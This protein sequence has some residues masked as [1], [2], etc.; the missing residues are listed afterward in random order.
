M[1][2]RQAELKRLF[3][4]AAGR[5]LVMSICRTRLGP[6]E[7]LVV[8]T[9]GLRKPISRMDKPKA[10]VGSHSQAVAEWMIAAEQGPRMAM[11]VLIKSLSDI[12]KEPTKAGKAWVLRASPRET[13]ATGSKAASS[14]RSISGD[15]G[16]L[17]IKRS[18]QHR[19]T[20]FDQQYS[21]QLERFLATLVRA[22]DRLFGADVGC[23][24][25][26]ID[27]R[28]GWEGNLGEAAIAAEVYGR[29]SVILMQTDPWEIRLKQLEEFVERHERLPSL[30]ARDP[31]EASL[32]VWLK[33]QNQ[34]QSKLQQ[35]RLQRLCSA[36]SSL[37]RNRALM[38]L[39][40]GQKFRY[41][42]RCQELK[43]YLD[44]HRSL[45]KWNGGTP[46]EKRLAAWLADKRG[47]AKPEQLLHLQKLHPLVDIYVQSWQVA[48]LKIQK[49]K[50]I[51]SLRSLSDLVSRQQRLPRRRQGKLYKWM[52]LQ[53]NRLSQ[54]R[55][56][57][58]FARQLLNAHPLIAQAASRAAAGAPQLSN[59]PDVTVWLAACFLA[60]LKAPSVS[61]LLVPT[62]S[63]PVAVFQK[64][65]SWAVSPFALK[66]LPAAFS[67]PKT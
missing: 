51:G 50:W 31:F 64:N 43:E 46:L 17:E 62:E 38:W 2:K 32:G 53:L 35:Q 14:A 5:M 67:S 41:V 61:Q 13:G 58:K 8:M 52:H 15:T 27:C 16:N 10:Q 25:R 12:H 6:A 66:I 49:T 9:L 1:N 34:K 59:R 19:G 28:L 65:E 26:V 21:S 7:L 33:N 36:S 55:L 30:S 39:K 57:H 18:L 24:I 60:F 11:P 40:G 42:E 22:D 20:S 37:I 4:A 48:P 56:P 23:R 63:G 3:F 47:H 45:P 44:Q 29:L 54:K